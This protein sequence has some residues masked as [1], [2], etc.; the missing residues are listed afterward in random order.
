M[1]DIIQNHLIQVMALVAM[2][3][4]CTL[5]ADDIRDEKLKVLRCTKP[6]A[7]DNIVIGQYGRGVDADGNLRQG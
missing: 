1:R 7:S 5:S 4:P 3:R 6:L 2:E